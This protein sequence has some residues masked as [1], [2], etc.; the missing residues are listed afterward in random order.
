MR[1]S[2]CAMYRLSESAAEAGSDSVSGTSFIA[3]SAMLLLGPVGRITGLAATD[4]SGGSSDTRGRGIDVASLNAQG[5]YCGE[6]KDASRGWPK[7]ESVK[8]KE[9]KTVLPHTR[10]MLVFIGSK[11]IRTPKALE[12]RAQKRRNRAEAWQDKPWAQRFRS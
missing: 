7:I 12:A 11:S 3:K 10:K 6:D 9:V 5:R 1:V 2:V 8:Q 4:G